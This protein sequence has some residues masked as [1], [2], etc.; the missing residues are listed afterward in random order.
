MTTTYSLTAHAVHGV[1]KL[2]LLSAQGYDL[3]GLKR[4]PACLNH[5][6][7]QMIDCRPAC[8]LMAALLMPTKPSLGE[9]PSC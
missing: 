7:R 3:E 6:H 8:R 4:R 5:L 1:L 2:Y 9:Q